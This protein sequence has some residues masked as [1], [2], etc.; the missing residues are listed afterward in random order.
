METSKQHH[1]TMSWVF[2]GVEALLCLVSYH[3]SR[4]GLDTVVDSA[5][6]SHSVAFA[7]AAIAFAVYYF[8]TRSFPLVS[9]EKKVFYT[10]AFAV[11]FV[12]LVGFS[13]QW[14][15]ITIGGQEAVSL[16]KQHVL[17]ASDK[18]GLLLLNIGAKEANLAPQLE[19]FA[20]QFE[21]YAEREAQGAFS[22]ITGEGSVVSTLRNTSD[23]FRGLAQSVRDIDRERKQLYES[24]KQEIGEARRVL[25]SQDSE[26]DV[27]LRF[28]KQ[29]AEI[30]ELLTRMSHTSSVEFVNTVNQN[31]LRL[32]IMNTEQ[33]SPGQLKAIG[34]LKGIIE[35]AQDVMNK[36]TTQERLSDLK[37]ETFT[38]ITMS[39]AVLTYWQE[40]F[41]AWAYAIA[42][43][44]CPFFFIIL[45]SIQNWKQ[46]E[47][48]QHY[49]SFAANGNGRARQ[50]SQE[51]VE[52]AGQYTG[53]EV[54]E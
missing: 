1:D 43:D 47:Q 22:G 45:L 14:S 25:V 13:T 49:R 34:Q 8:L 46:E 17:Q 32:S 12:F 15:A 23:T 29:L 41:Y 2:I 42:I 50:V 51:F 52:T 16:H 37:V 35:G 21:R 10:I 44:I 40:I 28:G 11:F 7:G 54:Y 5:V 9:M 27:N 31:L 20:D 24:L 3:T 38:M 26:G 48:Q 6:M 33:S 19:N 18:Q 30:N 4:V 39:K 36:L 53:H